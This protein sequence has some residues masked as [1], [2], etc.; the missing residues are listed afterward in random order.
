MIDIASG[1]VEDREWRRRAPGRPAGA[2]ASGE[3]EDREWR[4]SAP[5][6]AF[7]FLRG[8]PPGNRNNGGDSFGVEFL[9]TGLYRLPA[10]INAAARWAATMSSDMHI[11]GDG[12]TVF[13]HACK[14]GVLSENSIRLG[15]RVARQN[16]RM[17]GADA[18]C[19]ALTRNV[20]R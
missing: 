8:Q 5:G 1:E 6:R 7:V 4:R 10:C 14:M 13:A 19:P 2:F 9:T 12:P 20:H 16:H 15:I 17:I 18:C 3:V 11:D